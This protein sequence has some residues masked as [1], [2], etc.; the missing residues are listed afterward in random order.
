MSYRS[1]NIISN[2]SQ[3]FFF[4]SF[5][6]LEYKYY[7]ELSEGVLRLQEQGKLAQLQTKWWK[8][9][10]G[11]GACSVSIFDLYKFKSAII[12]DEHLI[13]LNPIKYCSKIFHSLVIGYSIPFEY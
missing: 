3:F 4:K 5:S 7:S 10:K 13:P 2:V 8:E 11:G 6:S 12:G 1:T 9:K